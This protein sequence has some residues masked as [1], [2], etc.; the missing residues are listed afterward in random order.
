MQKYKQILTFDMSVSKYLSFVV[1][2]IE[3]FLYIEYEYE[4]NLVN[5]FRSF[6][7]MYNNYQVVLFARQITNGTL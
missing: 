1:V 2:L 4:S 3:E 7:N 5:A 6:L